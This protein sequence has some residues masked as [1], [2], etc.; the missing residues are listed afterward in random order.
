MAKKLIIANWKM[1]P[2]SPGRAVRL[3]R[4]IEKGLIGIKNAE[5][6]IAPPYLFLKD[7]S[8]VLKRA[9]LGA[10]NMHWQDIGPYTGEVSWHQLKHLHVTHVIVGHYERR[11]H[12]GETNEMINKK[13]KAA[14]RAGL[15]PVLAIGE[16]KRMPE[17]AM[18]L[19]L[20]RQL[21]RGLSGVSANDFKNGV[22][23]YEPVWA[24]GTGLA[25]TPQ[26]ARK[27]L[28]MIQEILGRIWKTKKVST[29]ILYGG[30]VNSKNA[31]SFL[32]PKGGAMHGMLVGGA[33]LKPKEFIKIVQSAANLE[34]NI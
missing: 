17:D 10:Q 3:A 6:V 13:V 21:S 23:A 31:Y 2:D 20:L 33:S 19:V 26:H 14:L 15:I 25:A 32:S 5:I 11:I 12:L 4:E 24:I 28:G 8:Q 18:R 7:V 9:K 1:N 16:Q 34:K 30:S 22:I 27:A 29:P